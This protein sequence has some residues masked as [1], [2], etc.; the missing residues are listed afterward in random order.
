V[1]RSTAVRR[2]Y[3]LFDAIHDPIMVS[4]QT[5]QIQSG[6]DARPYLV[7]GAILVVCFAVVM[8]LDSC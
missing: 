5:I 1:T 4:L 6:V 3:R 8:A 2:L 7:V